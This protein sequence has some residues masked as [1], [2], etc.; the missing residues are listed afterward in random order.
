MSVNQASRTKSLPPSRVGPA[1]YTLVICEK[2][3]AA[4][5]VAEALSSGAPEVI[6]VVGVS[7]FRLEDTR[8]QRYVV[9]AA[10]GHLYGISDTVKDRRVYPVLDLEWFPLG[11]TR[12]KAGKH[13]SSRIR[14][15]R[16]LS[17]GAGGFVN[18]CDFDI[19]GETI[20]YNI[21][22]YACGGREASAARAKFS[23]LTKE[24]VVHAFGEDKPGFDGL[25]RAGRLRHAIDFIW[26]VNLSRA[27]SESLRTG[28]GFRTISI[29]RVQGPT[30]NFIVE[31]EVDA[32]TFVPTPY[33][34]VRGTF[35]K[36]GATF[37]GKYSPPTMP[38]KRAADDV[39]GACEGREGVV[40]LVTQR[41]FK[42]RPPP[43]L[44]L[45]DLQKEA[46]RLFGYAP[47]RT[48]QIAERLYLG[49]MISYPRTGS[50]RLPKLDYRRLLSRIAAIPG[51]SDLVDQVLSR[52]SLN[53]TEGQ[54]T[55]PAHPAIYPTGEP[56]RRALPIEERRLFDLVV[57]R[58]LSCFGEEAVREARSVDI[59]VGE[60][61]FKMEETRVLVPGWL[62]L[63]ADWRPA[64]AAPMKAS[65]LREGDRVEVGAVTVEEHLRAR[66][67]RYN[68][69]TLLE[70]MEREEIGTKA[71]RA[72]IIS[73]LLDRGYVAGETLVPTEL[74]FALIEAMRQHCP[75]IISTS[76]TREI[77]AQLER[78]ELSGESGQELFESTLSS[79]L[80]QIGEIRLHEADIAGRMRSSVP[81]AT[82]G[83]T[84]L[85]GCPVCKE[86]RLWVVRSRKSGK[87]FVG[88]TNY[89]KGCRASAPLPQRGTINAASKP[90]GS[91]GW[92]VVYVRMGRHPWRLCVN[93][94]CPRKVNAYSMRG[95]QKRGG[96]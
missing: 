92:P 13:V 76:L 65:G 51:Y 49:A 63:A 5:R 41:A 56:T 43:P 52:G 10:T 73:T 15:I 39:K 90:C 82:F 78:V 95:L 75:Q 77:E 36:G 60:H 81:E 61:V 86:G 80:A 67:V 64:E 44:N 53:P 16:T 19:E 21:L 46:Y 47:S 88:C 62:K 89:A 22:R 6:K 7:A 55:D 1:G 34:T 18:A 2:P 9:C 20:G 14:A 79:L 93:D 12:D 85:G 29:G 54:G 57:R 70:K 91:C 3:D 48:L 83:R 35:R 58:F 23:A 28:S 66:P 11:A 84:V 33:W 72:D 31:K 87:R 69:A 26:G 96:R 71:T 50:Q 37:E 32:R 40:S 8:G 38:T 17:E 25:A 30:L 45:A 59:L 24:E 4:R 68:Q 94:R 74:G 42:Q 27:L